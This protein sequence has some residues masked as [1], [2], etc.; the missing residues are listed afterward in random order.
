[1]KK[2]QFLFAAAALVLASCS[3]EE[4]LGDNGTPDALQNA[5]MIAFS[6]GSNATTRADKTGADAATALGN[7]FLTYGVKTVGST[8]SVVF[9]TYTVAYNGNPG[10]GAAGSTNSNTKGWEYVGLTGLTGQTV[11]Y[12]D[13]DASNYKFQAWSIKGGA[14]TVTPA[15]SS[16]LTITGTAADLA[17]VYI[18]DLVSIDKSTTTSGVNTYGGIVTFTF[19]NGASKVRFGMYESIAGYKLSDV[20]FRSAADGTTGKGNNFDNSTTNARLDGSFTGQDTTSGTYTVTYDTNNK[21]T[22]TNTAT[23]PAAKYIDFGTFDTTSKPISESALSPTYSDYLTVLPNENLTGDMKLYI[24]FKLTSD[25]GQDVITVTGAA[26]TVPASSM[27]WSPNSAYTY[28][29]NVTKDNSGTTGT[30]GTAPTKLYPI[31]FDAIV[32]DQATEVAPVETNV[33]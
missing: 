2:I 11:R 12:W 6:A 20:T 1:M 31:T 24:D 25:D 10:A 13:Y 23:G 14:A 30:E 21:A 8:E 15:K 9:P 27:K 29:F 17:Q 3:N 19:R 32:V 26:V 5:K 7:K 33:N 22:M 28:L 4:Y 18:A 16:S